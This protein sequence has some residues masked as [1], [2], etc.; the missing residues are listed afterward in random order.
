[1][2]FLLLFFW[3]FCFVSFYFPLC[4]TYM[5]L[6]DLA[7]FLDALSLLISRGMGL[8]KGLAGAGSEVLKSDLDSYGRCGGK[9]VGIHS[10]AFSTPISEA[11]LQMAHRV[12]RQYPTRPGAPQGPCTVRL[13]ELSCR[14]PF[15]SDL[16]QCLHLTS[17]PPWG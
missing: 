1:M 16:E 3:F 4:K 6:F 12:R 17:L 7:E 13:P 14:P 8:R 15:L 11:R 2:G 5:C 10:D 9:P